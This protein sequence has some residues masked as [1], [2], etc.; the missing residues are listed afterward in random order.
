MESMVGAGLLQKLE[1]EMESGRISGYLVHNVTAMVP[2]LYLARC[3]GQK[4]DAYYLNW[5]VNERPIL[6]R[7]EKKEGKQD[8]AEG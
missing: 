8:E 4:G 7:R 3:V 1:L 2:F 5:A 6:K